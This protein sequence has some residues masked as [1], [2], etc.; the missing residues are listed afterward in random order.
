MEHPAQMRRSTVVGVCLC[1]SVLLLYAQSGR[2]QS[3]S[4]L[5]YQSKFIDAGG[6]RLHYLEFG[7][8]GLPLLFVHSESW[9]AH[10]YAKFAPRFKDAYH[11]LAV[12]R[13]GYGQSED[14]GFGYDVPAQ[15]ERLIDFLD[16][17]SID[18]AVFAG[19]SA[20]SKEMTYLVEHHV[21]RVAG[22]IYLAGPPPFGSEDVVDSDPTEAYK[23]SDR[24]SYDAP[25]LEKRKARRGY[26]PDYLRRDRP[27]IRVPALAFVD[28]G[29]TGDG[30]GLSYALAN[31]G[32]PRIADVVQDPGFT[33]QAA[34]LRRLITDE[35]FRN[36][37][38][39]SITDSV[40]RAY[41]HRLAEDDELQ[42]EV[43]RYHEQVILPSVLASQQKFKRAFGDNLEVVQLDVP[44]VT[45]YAY[46][47]SPEVIYP[48]IRLFLKT[49][50]ERKRAYDQEQRPIIDMHLH[51]HRLTDYGGGMPVCTNDQEILF[52]GFDPARDT[53]TPATFAEFKSCPSPVPSAGSD[54]ELMQETLALLDRHNIFAVTSGPLERVAA[55][56]R[57]APD[58]IIPAHAFGDPGAPTPDEFR[59]LV[60]SGDL[61]LFAE[62]S[63]QYQGQSLDDADFEPYF[64]LAEELD[65]P[66][67]IH[68]GEGPYGG[69]YWASPDYRARLTNPFQLE[70]VLIS[71]PKLRVYVMHYGSPL[72]DEMIALMYAHPQVYVDIAGNNWQYPRA[73]FYGQLKKL[74]DAGLGKRVMWGSDQMVWPRTI[75]IAIETIEKAPFLSEEQQRDIFYNNAVRFLR[76]SEQEIA[77]HHGK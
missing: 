50:R 21:D 15:A 18:Q 7:G 76:L 52:Q 17:V 59:R 48:H 14:P 27:T 39:D 10:T 28:R 70:E 31:V 16:A 44:L 69:P 5:P 66:V 56:R 54:E 33:I 20:P 74:M 61:A 71:H 22:L 8:T 19:N 63:P 12:T 49:I 57:A 43:Q 73:H 64:A 4:E 24:A 6:V 26:R 53:I 23:M 60:N 13:P 65:V 38:L 72:V 36:E 51:A 25:A 75:E 35:A 3:D 29:G 30:W 11:V 68:L 42:A 62:V 47:D 45:G 34:G 32:S 2:A 58:R 40:A 55:W 37:Q 41:F 77:R 1:V 9:D 67:G 46:R